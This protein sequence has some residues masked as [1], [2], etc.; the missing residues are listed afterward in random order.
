ME[1]THAQRL[2]L[3]NQYLLMSQLDTNNAEHY[4]RLKTIIERGYDLQIRELT[5][6]FGC[7]PE[8]QCHEIITTM[9]MFH[10][11]QESYNLL[12]PDA[13]NDVDERRL[14]FLGYDAETETQ[15]M[16]Y[17][18]FLVYTEQRYPQFLPNEH[19]FNSQ[20]PMT[21]K[22]QRMLAIWHTCPRQYH[23]SLSEIHQ[24]FNA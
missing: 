2:I 22:Y 9:D 24:L 16:N 13:Q 3:S 23:L 19:Q 4:E 10:A 17:V 21:N 5:K 12:T 1:M 6:E 11:I 20:V 7:L 14:R 18:R 15:S 8:T